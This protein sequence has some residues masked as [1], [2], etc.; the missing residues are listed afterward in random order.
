MRPAVAVVL[1]RRSPVGQPREVPNPGVYV[2]VKEAL[3]LGDPPH[4]PLYYVGPEEGLGDYLQGEARHLTGDVEGLSPAA[5]RR[6]P[7]FKHALGLVDHEG[8]EVGY[9]LA[10]ERRLHQAP[11]AP[12]GVA[13]VRDQ[14]LAHDQ[15]HRLV[16]PR[17]EVVAIVGP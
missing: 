5:G 8:G 11:L 6:S 9:A 7:P 15:L 14:A 2:A 1:G 10:V 17:L 16:V 12:P 13:L 3:C 4:A